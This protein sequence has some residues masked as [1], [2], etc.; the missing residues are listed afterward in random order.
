MVGRCLKDVRDPRGTNKRRYVRKR[1]G[2]RDAA[3]LSLAFTCGATVSELIELETGQWD[4]DPTK[5]GFGRRRPNPKV[6]FPGRESRSE[7]LPLVGKTL[8]IQQL[9]NAKRQIWKRVFYPISKWGERYEEELSQPGIHTIIRTR[10]EQIEQKAPAPEPPNAQKLRKSFRQLLKLKGVK[11]AIILDLMGLRSRRSAPRDEEKAD[12]A[13]EEALRHT[14][15]KAN[16][17][18][19][20]PS[21]STR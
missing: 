8:K 21:P 18:L 16:E 17:D 12:Q 14:D 11:D 10:Y 7:E 9:W 19:Q 1:R 6:T 5:D 15:R 20:I 13:M 4:P 2:A 3:L